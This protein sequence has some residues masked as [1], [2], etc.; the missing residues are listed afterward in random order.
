LQGFQCT[1]QNYSQVWKKRLLRFGYFE[2]NAIAMEV[3]VLNSP[4]DPKNNALLLSRQRRLRD[5]MARRGAC[6]L[7]TADPINIVYGCGVRNMTVFGMMGPSRF[8]L[9]FADGPTIL[10]EFAGSEHLA[11]G[12]ATVDEVRPA[13]GITANSGPGFRDS[14]RS[15]AAEVAAECRRHA[16]D[17]TSTGLQLAVERVD[18]LLTD[19]LREQGLEMLDATEVLLQA[20]RI[21]QSEEVEVMREAV[22]RVEHAVA[23]VEQALRAGATEVEV[24]AAFHQ[25]LIARGGEYVSTRLLQSGANTFPYFQEAGER[26]LSDGDL[27][28]IDTDAIGYG[29]YAV[30][31]SRTFLCGSL[32]PTPVQRQLYRRAYEQLQ[33]NA[34]LLAP[35]RSFEE[36]AVK[37]WNIPL[38]HRPYGYYC[39]LHGLGMCGEHPYVPLHRQGHPYPMT[40]EFEP[41]MVLCIESY[42]GEPG[43]AQGVKLEDQFLITAEGVERLTSYPFDRRLLG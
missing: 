40:G 14:V 37:A 39:L 30:D 34:A 24:W 18:F 26:V 17:R 38:E 13:P 5:V 29:G 27:L 11:N 22:H 12:I 6:A 8:M 16:G 36:F 20:R 9:L 3:S 10:F 42:I 32:E 1:C 23:C 31:L 25:D 33:Y 7:L 4:P 41:G 43:A 2:V 35:G 15:F 21:K 28:C 19:A